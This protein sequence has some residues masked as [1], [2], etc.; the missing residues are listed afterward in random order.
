MSVSVALTLCHMGLYKFEFE[1][2]IS[3]DARTSSIF[4]W[5]SR[6]VKKMSAL[7]FFIS[8]SKIHLAEV[9]GGL[10]PI[11]IIGVGTNF[12]LLVHV[13]PGPNK[14]FVFFLKK[15]GFE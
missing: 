3:S 7:I 8:T 13:L 1:F 4:F 5:S 2:S 14:R 10:V 6:H 12:G 11:K 9:Q 15:N